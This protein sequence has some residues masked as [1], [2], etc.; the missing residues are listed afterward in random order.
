LADVSQRPAQPHFAELFRTH[1]PFVWRVLRRHG[2]AEADLE[3][4]C[5]EVFV[6]VS[7]RLAEFEGR[8]SLRTWIYEIARRSGLAQRRS[9][10]RRADSSA[11]L[12][13]EL[14]DGGPGPEGA[15]EQLRALRWLE[16]ALARLSDEKREAFVLYELEEMTLAEVAQAQGCALNTVHYRVTTARAELQALAARSPRPARLRWAQGGP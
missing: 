1:A 11:A 16:A 7:R 5:Q 8:S 6:V 4:V 12:D 15:L 10:I 14:A 13:A 2:V 3:D 9:R